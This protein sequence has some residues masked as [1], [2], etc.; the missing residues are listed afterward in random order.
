MRLRL[1]MR[2]KPSI[3]DLDARHATDR[4]RWLFTMLMYFDLVQLIQPG[5]NGR[6][7]EL[8]MEEII[9]FLGPLVDA[10]VIDADVTLKHI[11]EWSLIGAR[12][13]LLC[14]KFGPG[15]LFYLEKQ[16]SRNL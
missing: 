5:G 16:L 13:A 4:M 10:G 14:Q 8:M 12:V 9:H 3:H 6:V 1:E 7:G 2:S 15:S 11:N